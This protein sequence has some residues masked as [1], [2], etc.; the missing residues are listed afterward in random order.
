MDP[1]TA[2]QPGGQG[3]EI[4]LA[5]ETLMPPTV[6]ALFEATA[7]RQPDAV[8][9]EADGVGLTYRG[10]RNLVARAAAALVSADRAGRRRGAMLS[11]NRAECRPVAPAT[12]RCGA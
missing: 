7:S 3:A 4:H 12:A 10:L 5:G 9:I 11:D 1:G 2:A 8:A 6:S